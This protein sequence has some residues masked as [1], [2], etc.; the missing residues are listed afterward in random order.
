MGKNKEEKNGMW[1]G[2][3]VSYMGLHGWIRNHKPKPELCEECNIK[4]TYDLANISGEYKR[5]INDFK[6]L[7]RGCHMK[8]DGRL[9]NNLKNQKVISVAP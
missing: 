6:W 8:S 2:D 7:C 1:K 9:I 3:E 5:D 4:H